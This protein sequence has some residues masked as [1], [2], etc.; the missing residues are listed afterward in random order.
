MFVTSALRP[1]L[2]ETMT[3]AR[4]S[5]TLVTVL[6]TVLFAQAAPAHAAPGV[7]YG[8]TDDAWL[9]SGS[10][11]LE[12]R[13]TTL[14]AAGVQ[15]V[16]FNLRWNEIARAKPAQPADPADPAYDWEAIDPVVKGLRAHGLQVVLGMVGTPAWAN[17]GQAS[18]YIPTNPRSFGDFASAAARQY[19]WVKK[20]LVWNEPNQQ[21]WLKPTRAS[22]YTSRLLNP[23]YAAI[24]ARIRGA[25]V[26]GGVTA[27]RG[28][29]GGVSPVDWIAGMRAAHARL[30]AYAQH[31][32]PLNPKQETPI[33]GGCGHCRTITLADIG[34]LVTLVT[35]DFGSAR[36]WITEYGYQTNP[37]DRLLGVSP[38]L[39]ARYLGQAAL[40]A[41][42]T[43]RVDMLIHFLYRDEADIARFQSGLVTVT[44]TAKLALAGFELPLA[45]V[46]RTGT[47]TTLW[48][49]L[50][51]PAA[52]TRYRLLKR[53]GA[54]WTT[55]AS[56][57]ARRGY[58]R[59]VSMLPRGTQVRAVAGRVTSA[60]LLVT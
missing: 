18:N 42:R 6:L 24:H 55:F 12:K 34:R 53:D 52:G 23:A 36:I 28:S 39:Q 35:R 37:P 60:T 27:P 3:R 31:A 13:L 8:L 10:G 19:P 21:R 29:S 7:K 4:L 32:Y 54:R 45:E 25:Q 50:R 47:R 17:G 26:A 2:T 30:D 14:G 5:I 44:G 16:R 33:S 20:W 38:T 11:T 22:L 49:E 9:Q 48:G 57:A 46:S 51:A 59:V 58:F 15:I 41:Y 56:G 40:Q 1:R 43:P